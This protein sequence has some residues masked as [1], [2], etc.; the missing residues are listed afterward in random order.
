MEGPPPKAP[1]TMTL[2]AKGA[3]PGGA[4]PARNTCDGLDVPLA[5]EWSGVP[6]GA[7]ELAIL[8]EDPDA[9]GGTF[10]HWTAFGID[11]KLKGGTGAPRGAEQGANSYGRAGWRGPCPPEGDEPHRY[12]F[13]IYALGKPS[14]LRTNAHPRKVR[15]ALEG[16]L[17]RGTLTLRYGR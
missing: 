6:A 12:V 5:L 17:A 10:V 8:V 16:A 1:E 15:K 13:T 4:M 2:T 11:P 7:R 9:E 14:G 3:K